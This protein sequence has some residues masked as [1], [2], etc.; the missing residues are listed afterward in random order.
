MRFID[1]H[2]FPV[3]SRTTGPGNRIVDLLRLAGPGDPARS[4]ATGGCRAARVDRRGPRL[5]RVRWHLRVPGTAPS[6]GSVG[7]SFD[8]ALAENL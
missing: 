3:F 5:A 1:A 7:D 8:G 4:A 2:D 6:T